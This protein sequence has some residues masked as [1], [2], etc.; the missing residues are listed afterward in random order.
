MLL[1]FFSNSFVYPRF[2]SAST[3]LSTWF[4]SFFLFMPPTQ[5]FVHILCPWSITSKEQRLRGLCAS[6]SYSLQYHFLSA[7]LLL[8]HPRARVISDM[9]SLLILKQ[10]VIYD[11]WYS[12]HPSPPPSNPHPIPSSY[13][14]INPGLHSRTWWLLFHVFVLSLFCLLLLACRC[15]CFL[16]QVKYV[17]V[18]LYVYEHLCA[19]GK[20]GKRW[21][22]GH[23]GVSGRIIATLTH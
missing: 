13:V 6:V 2:S 22:G 9:S 23:E 10:A 8:H 7:S 19:F 21:E 1:C 4:L 3:F 18:L 17:F 5:L 20:G 11:R 14:T 15:P 12:N 16:S